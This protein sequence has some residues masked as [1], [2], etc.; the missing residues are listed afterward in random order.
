MPTPGR[1]VAV[2][3]PVLD[4]DF[5]PPLPAITHAIMVHGDQSGPLVAEVQSHLNERTVRAIALQSTAGL[6]R[7]T[8][9][10]TTGAPI[11]IPVGEQVLGRIVNVLGQPADGG[12]PLPDA[13]ERWSI[14]RPPLFC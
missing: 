7:G 10:T 5:S 13:M 14:H 8:N 9:T 6:K 1:V 4:V 12:P 2:R 11:M 3:G